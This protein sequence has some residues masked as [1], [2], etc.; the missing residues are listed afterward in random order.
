MGL[1]RNQGILASLRIL[2]GL[3]FALSA[4]TAS[5][6][7]ASDIMRLFGG[8]M[9][10][11]IVEAAKA[12]W[13]KLR[14]VELACIEQELQR[15]GLS[16]TALAQR[17]IL[18]TDG[19]IAGIRASCAAAAIEAREA[20]RPE[21]PANYQ[22]LSATP[23]F[24]CMKARSGTGR[25]LCADQAGAKA[26]WDISAAYWASMASVPEAERDAFRRA[27]DD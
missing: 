26:D 2:A 14:P 7:N 8:M 10:G 25:V 20:V 18:P 4:S 27:H 19:R 11:A 3:T 22:P 16:P 23:T 12:E 15:Q 13:R 5:A 1:V 9:Q 24:D 21:A 17:G 6:Q